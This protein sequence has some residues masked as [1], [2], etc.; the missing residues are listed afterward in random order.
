MPIACNRTPTYAELLREEQRAIE[1]F[2]VQNNINVLRTFP[3]D[4]VFGEND[5][6][7][8]RATGVFFNIVC[9]GRRFH[10]DEEGRRFEDPDGELDRI[11]LGRDIHIRFRG[12]HFFQTNDTIRHTNDRAQFPITM[13]FQGPVTMQNRG[14]YQHETPA[15]MVPLQHIGDGAVVRMIVPFN[16]GSVLDRSRFQ[17]SFYEEIDYTFQWDWI[18]PR[19]A[20]E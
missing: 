9:R 13:R 11:T 14:M 6:W 20:K 18:P 2:I 3:P 4:T 15:F 10:F 7:E 12:L 1:R 19:S 17:A 8:C 16:M 5:F